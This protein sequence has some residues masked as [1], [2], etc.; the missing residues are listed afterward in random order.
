[1]QV[2]KHNQTYYVVKNQIND[3]MFWP[4]SI[5]IRP[6]LGLIEIRIE[7]IWLCFLTCIFLYPMFSLFLHRLCKF[8]INTDHFFY[9]FL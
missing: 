4:V 8:S 7:I 1:M 5:S 2:K 9:N 3:N 6:S